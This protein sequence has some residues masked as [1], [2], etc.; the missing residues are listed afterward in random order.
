MLYILGSWLCR[1]A[2]FGSSKSGLDMRILRASMGL[3]TAALMISGVAIGQAQAADEPVSL[4]DAITLVPTDYR[5]QLIQRLSIAE[6]NQ[7]QWLDTIATAKPEYREALAFLLVNMPDRDL[8]KLT[9]DYVMKNVE[10]AYEARSAHPWT[11]SVP[12]EIFFDDVLPY[13]NVNESREDLA[14]GFR[15]AIRAAGER[16]RDGG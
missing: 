3:W 2:R 12:K 13:A 1:D 7:Q 9:G 15:E 4:N 6:D 5:H 16:L 8:M 11:A 14:D 10:L